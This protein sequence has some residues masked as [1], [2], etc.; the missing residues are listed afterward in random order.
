[1]HSTFTMQYKDDI[2]KRM[3]AEA[4]KINDNATIEGS[5]ARD[6]INANSVE[7]ENAYA[8]MAL[9]IQAAFASTSWGSF[10]TARAA[11]YGV[12]RKQATYAK[13]T[14]TVEGTSGAVIPLQSIVSVKDGVSFQTEASAVIPE[15]GRV[16]IPVVCTRPGKAGNVSAGTVTVFPV[17]IAGAA[18]VSNAKPMKNGFEAETDKELYAR[19]MTIVRTPATSGNKFHYYNWAMSVPGIGGCKVIPLWN[20]PGTVKVVIVNADRGVASAELIQKV[21]D[22]IENVRPVGATVT[23]VSPKPVVVAIT[24]RVAGT[25]DMDGFLSAMKNF[26]REKNLNEN[27][28]SVAQIGDIL[29][30]YGATDYDNLLLNGKTRVTVSEEQLLTIGEVTFHEL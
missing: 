3:V 2:Q 28:I 18:R 23:V 13:G 7:F 4:A 21:A 10:L 6:I 27:S 1:M 24:G 26:L 30:N 5:F 17:P 8:E 20:G 22:Y 25:V 16:D 14:V 12:N 9:I 29:M 19:Y 15:N 11:E